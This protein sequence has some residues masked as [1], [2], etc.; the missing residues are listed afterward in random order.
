MRVVPGDAA[1]GDRLQLCV[2]GRG[3]DDERRVKLLQHVTVLLEQQAE[4]L[5]H[6][7]AHDVHFKRAIVVGRVSPLR[8]ACLI[9]VFGAHGVT[10]PTLRGVRW[11]NR[12]LLEP[13]RPAP[14]ARRPRRAATHAPRANRN[15]SP[16]TEIRRDAPR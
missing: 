13:F 2:L 4:E 5:L 6:V 10:R 9:C 14:P 3:V 8:A 11:N 15:P 16:A 1:F 7:M 12:L